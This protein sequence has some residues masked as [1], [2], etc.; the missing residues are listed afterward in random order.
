MRRL[1]RVSP[2]YTYRST[3]RFIRLNTT[4]AQVAIRSAS[5]LPASDVSRALAAKKPGQLW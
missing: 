2:R 4:G 1:L 5:G 3:T